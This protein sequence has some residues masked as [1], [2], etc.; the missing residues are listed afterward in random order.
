[1]RG[2]VLFLAELR[3]DWEAI[4][5]RVGSSRSAAECLIKFLSL[6]LLKQGSAKEGPAPGIAS[7]FPLNELLTQVD[8]RGTQITSTP[9]PTRG[10]CAPPLTPN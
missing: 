1:V 3:D 4:A 2:G 7:G 6:P 9:H 10:F 8:S 5:Q